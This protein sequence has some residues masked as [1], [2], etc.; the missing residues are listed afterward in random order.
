MFSFSRLPVDLPPGWLSGGFQ[1]LYDDGAGGKYRHGGSDLACPIGTPVYAPAEGDAV[2]F[3]WMPTGWDF[4]NW[5]LIDH[6]VQ[7]FLAPPDLG[8]GTMSARL[9]SAYAHLSEF[10]IAGGHVEAGQLI[11]KSGTTGKS[12]GP[13]V[14]WAMGTNRFFARDFTQLSDCMAHLEEDLTKEDTQKLIDK[15]I[16]DA[17]APILKEIGGPDAV[18]FD[19]LQ[20][21]RNEQIAQAKFQED[22]RQKFAAIYEAAKPQATYDTVAVLEGIA[23]ACKGDE[24]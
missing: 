19:L 11:G 22:I 8:G 9:Y 17:L 16:Q 21:I 24:S 5:I 7:T 4:G 13:H 15:S 3:D 2:S 18:N 12:G 20:S 23:A 1:E 14:H 10:A 6:G